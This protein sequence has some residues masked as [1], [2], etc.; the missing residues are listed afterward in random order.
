LLVEQLLEIIL[1]FFTVNVDCPEEEPMAP[2]L[3]A[4]D[5]APLLGLEA[6]P[7][8]SVPLMRS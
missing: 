7:L 2:E 4:L 3:E 5:P 8:L 6:D 1:T